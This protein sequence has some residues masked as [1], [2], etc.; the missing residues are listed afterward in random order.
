MNG[1]GKST[2][3]QLAAASYAAPIA[4]W[5]H[6]YI[7]TFLDS[8]TLD[9][10][11]F[12]D[13]A[14][15]E[16]KFW[17]EDRSL[18]SLTIS[19]GASRWSGYARRLQRFVQFAWVGCY[20]PW[21][22]Q[23]DAVVRHANNLTV[24]N[25]EDVAEHIKTWT[26]RILGRQYDNMRKNTVSYE[27][28]KRAV[29]RVQRGPNQYSEAHMGYGEARSQYLI[30]TIESLPANSLVLIEEPE[31]SLHSHAQYEFGCYLVDVSTRKGHQVLLTTHSEPLLAAL[32]SQSRV[33]LHAGPHGAEVIRGLT[34][35]EAKSLM[36]RG[37]EK[38][39][40]VLVEDSVASAILT[41][42]IRRVDGTL[43]STIGIY[44]AG[45]ASEISAA[46]KTVGA[47]GLPVAGV[48]DGDKA[49]NPGENIFKLPGTQPPERELFRNTA[50]Q[51]LIENSYR[52]DLRDFETGLAGVNHH[53]WCERLAAR[54]QQTEAALVAEMARAYARSLPEIDATSLR[55]L[56]REASRQ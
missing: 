19:R 17:Q 1:T 23:R 47:T 50:V 9:P 4:D 33:Y 54:V 12:T 20:L 10:S 25:S 15:V 44:E 6:Y 55:D 22:E 39:L 56:L 51:E 8:G 43:L 48:L 36:T 45:G 38:A 53:E 30:Q 40:H 28:Q 37:H 14:R 35:T 18:K 13:D 27:S 52:L 32:P 29:V 26:C 7:R 21:I 49:G 41:E 11:P 3:L 46:V 5:P 2:L 34:A 24:E 31:I 16:Y 42:L